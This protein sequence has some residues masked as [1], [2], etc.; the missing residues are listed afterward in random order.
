[1]GTAYESSGN[2]NNIL[3]FNEGSFSYI[4]NIDNSGTIIVLDDSTSWIVR[5]DQ[6]SEVTEW[7][8]NERVILDNGKQFII[9]TRIYQMA[10]VQEVKK[11]ER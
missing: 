10:A 6:R 5:P 4:S 2:I 7:D 9:N 11:E 3:K 1:M 8:K